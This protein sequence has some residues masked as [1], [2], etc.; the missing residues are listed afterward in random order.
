MSFCISKVSDW[1]WI[2]Y[3]KHYTDGKWVGGET[4]YILDATDIVKVLDPPDIQVQHRYLFYIFNG[5]YLN[6][7][8]EFYR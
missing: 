5:E 7:L 6:K 8:I 4:Q 1:P 2:S 3:Y